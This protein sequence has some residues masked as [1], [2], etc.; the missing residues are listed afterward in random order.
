MYEHE[1]WLHIYTF[2]INEKNPASY[3]ILS[4]YNELYIYEILWRLQKCEILCFPFKKLKIYM[5]NIKS[6]YK[7]ILGSW[8]Y[9]Y[10]P[11]KYSHSINIV[12]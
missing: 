10:T 12:K 5:G 7:W 3:Q 4:T 6:E 11:I 1:E 8:G 9:R 2:I